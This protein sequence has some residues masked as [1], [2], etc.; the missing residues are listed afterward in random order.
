MGFIS[1]NSDLKK[2]NSKK[3]QEE[4]MGAIALVV[5]DYFESQN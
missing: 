2:L 1:N 4:L 5:E 3:F